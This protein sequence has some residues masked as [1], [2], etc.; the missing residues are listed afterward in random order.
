M[1]MPFQITRFPGG[2]IRAGGGFVV[3]PVLE[4]PIIGALPPAIRDSVARGLDL[5]VD[6]ERLRAA[7]VVRAAAVL[8][9]TRANPAEARRLA[10]PLASLAPPPRVL[11][12]QADRALGEAVVAQLRE[13]AGV[14][15][16][17]VVTSAAADAFAR[18]LSSPNG[19]DLAFGD[20]A[21]LEAVTGSAA[22]GRTLGPPLLT[23]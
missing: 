11:L 12:R 14:I 4:S 20:S 2:G 17:P 8:R 23:L 18:R 3:V 21:F 5:A 19:P 13:Q 15:L 9:D 6:R 10:E 7:G 16:Q 1:L 22:M